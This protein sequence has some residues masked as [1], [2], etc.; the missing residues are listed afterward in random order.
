MNES[1]QL[2]QLTHLA[3]ELG[4]EVRHATLGG[5]GGGVC[6]IRGRRVLFIDTTADLATR[7]ECVVCALAGIPEIETRFVRP[8]LRELLGRYR[9]TD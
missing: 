4:L 3:E 7:L 2:N 9:Q 5:K 1:A 8:E 6:T